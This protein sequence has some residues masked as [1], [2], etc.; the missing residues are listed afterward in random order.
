[1][2]IKKYK[3]I[4]SVMIFLLILFIVF[5]FNQNENNLQQIKVEAGEEHNLS[6][7]AWS[8]N[9][10]WISFNCLDED[11]C[12]SVN[13]GVN[14]ESNN[15]LSGYAWSDNIGWIS[16]NES[17]L[18]N[19]PKGACKAQLVGG[20]LKGWAKALAGDEEN[21][22]WDG[23]IS[24]GTQ[25]SG[26]ID[27]E[28]VLN[29]SEFSGYA[30]GSDVVG[31]IDFNP[32]YGGVLLN[33]FSPPAITQFNIEN[34]VN[35]GIPNI[36]WTTENANKCE[37]SWS[38][39]DLCL[40]EAGCSSGSDVG[41]VVSSETTYSITCYGTGGEVIE[42]KTADAYYTLKFIDPYDE[43]VDIEFVVSG[44]TTTKT[45][46]GVTPWNGFIGN[47]TLDALLDSTSPEVLPNESYSIYS[48]RTLSSAEYNIGSE[49]SIFVAEPINGAHTVPISGSAGILGT[50]DLIINAEGVSP[51]WQEI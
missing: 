36:S 27:Y 39:T 18:D 8:E 50:L 25:P 38:S 35:G 15:E 13:Y 43:N 22:G 33:A 47:V 31:W 7:Y 28:V 11:T 40:N 21:D 51:L 3:D 23:W 29:G 16:F 14:L 24:L 5:S 9:I 4:I 46:I 42:S 44:A 12:G 1:M 2:K 19:C 34:V 45:R 6:G 17:D 32:A 41:D 30:W 49:I 37:G 48:D 20:I 10:G 26:T